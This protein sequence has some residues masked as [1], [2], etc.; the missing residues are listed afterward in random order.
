M[1][2][3]SFLFGVVILFVLFYVYFD[4]RINA[5]KNELLVH[6]QIFEEILHEKTKSKIPGKIQENF[7]SRSSYGSSSSFS[8]ILPSREEQQNGL[9]YM[10]NNSLLSAFDETDLY[11]ASW[12]P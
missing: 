2:A 4:M 3:S 1:E 11:A 5:L 7:K 12:I 9:T 10:M 8:S 6:Y